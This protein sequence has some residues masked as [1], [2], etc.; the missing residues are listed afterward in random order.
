MAT[1]GPTPAKCIPECYGGPAVLMSHTVRP[2]ATEGWVQK[3]AALS[4]QP[5]DWHFMGG[6]IIV[7]TSK[8]ADKAKVF[9]ALAE[10]KPEWDQLYRVEDPDSRYEVPWLLYNEENSGE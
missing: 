4:G 7:R 2:N 1:D 8:T 10:L 5:V 3:V 6:R 9:E